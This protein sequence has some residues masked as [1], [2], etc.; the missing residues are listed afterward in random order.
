MKIITIEIDNR[1]SNL[2]VLGKLLEIMSYCKLTDFLRPAVKKVIDLFMG[3]MMRNL[4]E[5]EDM[6]GPRILKTHIPFKLLNPKLLDTSKVSDYK[7]SI[8]II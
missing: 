3:N 6:S 1:K 2:P 5:M 7:S 8:F 4:E